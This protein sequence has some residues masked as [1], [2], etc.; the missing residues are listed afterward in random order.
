MIKIHICL[1]ALAGFFS[2]CDSK[3]TQ[4]GQAEK[5][6]ET[7]TL[8]T[9]PYD[10]KTPVQRFTLPPELEEISGLSYYK[11]NQLLCVQD[12]VAVAYIYDVKKQQIADSSVFG[13]YG[14]FEGIEWVKNEIYTLKS[15]GDLYH[16]K[17]FSKSI[18]RI[19]GNLP[20]KTEVEGLAYDPESNRLLIPVKEGGR[21]G[22]KIVYMYDLKS[23]VLYQGMILKD[24]ALE[25]AGIDAKKFKPSGLAVHPQT[26][27]F[28]FLTSIGKKLVVVN[29]KGRIVASEALDPKVFR[30]P[31]GI[32][33]APDGTLYIA[34]EGDGKAG[35]IL[36]FAQ[37]P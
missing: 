31:E 20:S 22:Q 5:P 4:A 21:K 1:L 36:S 37:R 14:D 8:Q 10:L 26:G 27:N 35:Y 16:F 24:E 11:P 18:A 2:A 25:E 7:Q 19:P 6:S 34:S 15:N 33:F 17:P 28:Y 13:N 12:E 29:R 3:K 30:Q 32:C 9:I 23:K